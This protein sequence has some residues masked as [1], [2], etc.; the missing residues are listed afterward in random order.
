MYNICLFCLQVAEGSETC[1]L[2]AMKMQNS[3]VATKTAKVCLC[4]LYCI[5]AMR[6]YWS[7]HVNKFTGYT[8]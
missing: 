5:Y 7:L 8:L 4:S 6:V 2:E 1:V 3:L